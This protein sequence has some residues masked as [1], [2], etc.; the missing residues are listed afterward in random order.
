[1]EVVGGGSGIEVGPEG[2]HDLLAVEAVA[3]REREQLNETGGL[4]QAPSGV[5]DD[6]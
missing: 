4:A 6:S 1:M 5:L 3:G 2:L